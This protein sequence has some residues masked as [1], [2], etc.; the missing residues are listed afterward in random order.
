[1]A[2]PEELEGVLGALLVPDN[3]A[4]KQAEAR[5][6]ELSKTP[7]FLLAMVER[8]GASA[9]PQ[10]R[11]LAA[12]VARRRG[13]KHWVSPQLTA[14]NREQIKNMLLHMLTAEP[15]HLVR[16]SVADLISAIAKIAV[17]HGQWDTLLQFLFQCSLSEN[18]GHREVALVVFTS[19]TDAIGNLLRQH[20]RQL[21]S[22]FVNGLSDQAQPVRVAAVKAVGVVVQWLEDAAER[23]MFAEV[24]PPL[25]L[26]TQQCIECGDEDTAL[27]AIEMLIEAI[28]CNYGVLEASLP[29]LLK[30]MID[31]A[32]ARDKVEVQVRE[33]AMMFV[34]ELAGERPKVIKKK[35]LLPMILQACF[36]LASEPENEEADDEDEPVYKWGTAPIDML[37]KNLPSKA[38][39]PSV[40]AHVT[41]AVK[42][43]DK[44][45][46]RGALYVLGLCAEHCSES[47]NEM[48]DMLLPMLLGGLQDGDKEVKSAACWAMTQFAEFCQPEI[49]EH[50]E[51]MLP[52]IFLALQEHEPMVKRNAMHALDA[53]CENLGAEELVPY[54]DQL[55][56]KMGELLQA[57]SLELRELAFS[58]IAT[59]AGAAGDQFAKFFDPTMQHVLQ[60]MQLQAEDELSLRARATECGGV[61]LAACPD[62]G[63]AFIIDDAH[64]YI[65]L[66]LQGLSL[67]SNELREYSYGAFAN[68]ALLL[69]EEVAALAPSVMPML[70][71]SI[72][73]EDGVAAEYGGDDETGLGGAGGGDDSE[74]EDDIR[75]I[76]VR[77]AWLDEKAAAVF[78]LGNLAEAMG[79]SFLPHLEQSLKVVENVAQYFHEDVRQNVQ[80][81]LQKLW[82]VSFHA[83]TAPM[84]ASVQD[85]ALAQQ[86][87][88]PHTSLLLDKVM[89]HYLQ[90]IKSDDDKE[91]VALACEA[92]CATIPLVGGFCMQKSLAQIAQVLTQLFDEKAACQQ[93]DDDDEEDEDESDHDQVL[94]DAVA[95]LLGAVAKAFQ[96]SFAPHFEP[97]FA[98][99]QKYI[100]PSRQASDRFMAIGAVAET[101]S[102]LKALSAPYI[103]HM[104]PVLA[105]GLQEDN[106][107]VKRNSAFCCG[108]F[109]LHCPQQMEP[110]VLQVLQ[111]LQPLLAED[112]EAEVR[113]NAI[114]AIARIIRGNQASVPTAQLVG[115]LAD[116]LPLT[117]DV[118]ENVEVVACL[119]SVHR[120]TPEALNPF[121]GKIVSGF[122]ALLAESDSAK[123]LS[124]Q[125]KQEMTAFIGHLARE[126]AEPMQGVFA[127][128]PAAH[129]EWL[130][131]NI[132]VVL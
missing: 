56:H 87:V 61:L 114:G 80:A 31:V 65:Q 41:Q 82:A 59:A 75:A 72:E 52:G 51:E 58:V 53:F 15:E 24:L 48:L 18:P 43:N 3:E 89:A 132:S 14:D 45:V 77:T 123:A 29:T 79:A 93:G 121:L 104:L 101:C 112:E 16:R 115:L 91:T 11:Q 128:C 127:A 60:C 120:A 116:H 46:R 62:L 96:E 37:A 63:R 73:S 81:C 118:D 95:E 67:D 86:M 122:V 26:V 110:F 23:A 32:V 25:L 21:T 76:T 20:F 109:C 124:D 126:Y 55:M 9:S 68:L 130:A 28:D 106:H 99:L 36:T 131:A 70:I 47:Y 8:A 113:D 12:V 94:I 4:I 103:P 5:L 10:V 19:L 35:H 30:F 88:H 34:S 17:P 129:Q 2:S 102:H 100:K 108:V 57:P 78:C 84:R 44:N 33:K 69:K 50:Y 6:K 71:T 42:S 83:H 117:G 54:L 7:Q 40:L 125:S 1:M 111:G 74:D 49:V 98:L 13:A 22:I 90:C 39:V 105:A 107:G 64:G 92:L 85:P 119:L 66:A 97:I 27:H 38:V